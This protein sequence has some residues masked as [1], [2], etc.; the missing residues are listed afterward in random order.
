MKVS[1]SCETFFV[2]VKS[3]TYQTFTIFDFMKS[4]AEHPF[5]FFGVTWKSWGEYLY[6]HK[7][8]IEEDKYGM[9]TI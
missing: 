8:A 2:L 9:H 6:L 4:T 3:N 7:Q 5:A 1:Q